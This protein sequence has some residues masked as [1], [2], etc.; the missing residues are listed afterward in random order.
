MTHFREAHPKA[1]L[2]EFGDVLISGGVGESVDERIASLMGA[3]STSTRI[4]LLFAL[5]EA[6]ELSAGE[7]AKVIGMSASATSHQLRILRDLGLIRRRREGRRVIY[8]LAD[9]H[10]AVLLREALY[11]V[12]HG[13]LLKEGKL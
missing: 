2:L 8:T 12:D 10:L 7:L 6:E 1:R 11:H 13:R 5:L 4:R 3:L 9:S